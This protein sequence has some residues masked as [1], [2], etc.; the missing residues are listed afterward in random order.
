MENYYPFSNTYFWEPAM[1][2]VAL[3]VVISFYLNHG[4]Q[5][6]AEVVKRV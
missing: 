1:T 6:K 4:I 3:N 2:G 5:S